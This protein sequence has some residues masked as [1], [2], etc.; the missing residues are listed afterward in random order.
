MR[1]DRCNQL[2]IDTRFS[3]SRFFSS[4]AAPDS[5]S[6]P[7]AELHKI[8][9]ESI[10]GHISALIIASLGLCILKTSAI[11]RCTVLEINCNL[12]LFVFTIS[13]S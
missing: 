13:S 12:I 1:K 5:G 7:H 3:C 2:Y 11:A 4:L 10:L 6:V 8:P 9:W